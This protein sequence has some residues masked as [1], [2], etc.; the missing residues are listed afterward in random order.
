MLYKDDAEFFLRKLRVGLEL[1]HSGKELCTTRNSHDTS[2]GDLQ[3]QKAVLPIQCNE[4]FF[5]GEGYEAHVRHRD[6]IGGWDL[7]YDF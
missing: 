6:G 1:A 7:A 5:A 4:S 3:T 2:D